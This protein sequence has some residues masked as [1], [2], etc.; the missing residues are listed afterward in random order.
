MERL[1]TRRLIDASAT[2]DPAARA[3]LNLWVNRGLP[4]AALA[5]MTGMEPQEIAARRA[6]IVDQLSAELGLPPD[7]ISDALRAIA[8]MHGATSAG[9]ETPQSQGVDAEAATPPSRGVAAETPTPPSP[10]PKAEPTPQPVRRGR[11]RAWIATLPLSIVALALVLVLLLTGGSG[12]RGRATASTAGTTPTAPA[13]ASP[14]TASSPPTVAQSRYHKLAALPGGLA[15]ARGE[16]RLTGNGKKLRLRLRVTHLPPRAHGHYEVW[17]YNTIIDSR[18]LARLRRGVR[19]LSLRLPPRSRHFRWIDISFQ[20]SGAIN[21]SGESVLR[22]SNP[23][24]ARR[25]R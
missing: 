6:Q 4:D 3:L 13:P 22:T 19:S 18:P 10:A 21:H 17:L 12:P 24:R 8:G 5:R 16:A 2:L 11:R 15:R 14:T 9:L 7:D 25:H 20:P 1:A 23:L